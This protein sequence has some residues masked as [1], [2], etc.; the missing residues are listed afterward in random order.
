M[1]RS[2]DLPLICGWGGVPLT[3]FPL[4]P[5]TRNRWVRRPAKLRLVLK[6]PRI[7]CPHFALL[8]GWLTTCMKLTWGRAGVRKQPPGPLHAWLT[9]CKDPIGNSSRMFRSLRKARFLNTRELGDPL[10]TLKQPVEG[11]W[12][13][14]APNPGELCLGGHFAGLRI[15]Q[16][17]QQGCNPPN[18]TPCVKVVYSWSLSLPQRR[19][20]Y[21]CK[22]TV[23]RNVA[24]E[25]H[26]HTHTH[27]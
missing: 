1:G 10:R 22:V 15:K 6:P 13:L 5:V 16:I 26:T 14:W 9:R 4:G 21:F 25:S 3:T 2:Q 18:F 17:M 24:S 27:Q 20:F 23:A 19:F 11:G 12:N 7:A 8:R